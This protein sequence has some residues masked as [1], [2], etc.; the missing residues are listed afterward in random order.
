[1]NIELW[2]SESSTATAVTRI[3]RPKVGSCGSRPQSALAANTVEN[4]IAIAAPSMALAVT[5]NCRPRSSTATRSPTPTRSPMA[6]RTG[7]PSQPW[8]T[9]YMRKNTAAT[10]R[11]I[12]AT[13][14]NSWTPMSFSKS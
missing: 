1:M 11:A 6:I 2:R 4:R 7:G 9:E 5:V 3:M 8:D 13:H 10:T 12:P 14:E